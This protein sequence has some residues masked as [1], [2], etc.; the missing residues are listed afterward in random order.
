MRRLQAF[1]AIE[2]MLLL[3]F[4]SEPLLEPA[5][6]HRSHIAEANACATLLIGPHEIPGALEDFALGEGQAYMDGAAHFSGP[7]RRNPNPRDTDVVGFGLQSLAAGGK[8][9]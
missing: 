3:Q 9:N 8:G 4:R 5:L 2:G 6:E 1:G 7:G